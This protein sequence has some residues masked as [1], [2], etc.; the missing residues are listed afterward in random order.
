MNAGNTRGGSLYTEGQLSS[1]VTP[2]WQTPMSLVTMPW[3]ASEI[4]NL[5][6]PLFLVL[7][8]PLHSLVFPPRFTHC[9]SPR[10]LVPIWI[11]FIPCP[12]IN[13]VII[14]TLCALFLSFPYCWASIQSK[15]LPVLHLDSPVQPAKSRGESPW[16][17]QHITNPHNSSLDLGS[18]QGHFYSPSESK[19]PQPSVFTYPVVRCLGEYFQYSPIWWFLTLDRSLEPHEELWKPPVQEHPEI[20]I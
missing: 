12:Q 1:Q 6:S 5:K 15:G 14:N 7:I 18:T 9:E 11:A 13:K 8:F 20:L 19:L 3:S 10:P 17:M 2:G 16:T 4:W